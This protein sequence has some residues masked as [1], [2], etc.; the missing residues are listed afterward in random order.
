[1]LV[2]NVM[3]KKVIAVLPQTTVAEA[4]DIMTRN[5]VSGLPVVD[6]NGV[7]V[8]IISEADFLRRAELG[9]EKSRAHWLTSFFLPGHAAEIYAR[10]H[11][12]RVDEIMSAEVAT[13]DESA[14]LNEAVSLMEKRRV[15]RLPV[16][17]G[18]KPIGMITRADFIAALALFM[19]QSYDQPLV[20]D[21]EIKRRIAAEMKAQPWAPVGSVDIAVSDGVVSLYGLLSDDRERSAIRALVESIDGVRDVHDH[22]GWAEPFSG[23]VLASP[24]DTPTA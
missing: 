17:A 24:E 2:K 5:R 21:A 18:G 22:M 16:V 3:T 7:L 23:V 8:G 4:L 12:Q 10:A 20:G 11:A 14:S 9:T 6:E 19:R 1:M 15:K 13:I